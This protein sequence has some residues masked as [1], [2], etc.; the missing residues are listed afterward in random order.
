MVEP[1]GR[2]VNLLL[3]IYNSSPNRKRGVYFCIVNS[4]H[5]TSINT[6]IL[7][8]A[9]AVILAFT[10][11]AGFQ[12]YNLDKLD[13]RINALNDQLE[14][15][16]RLFVEIQ[17]SLGYGGVIHNLKN[18]IIRRNTRYFQAANGKAG[19]ARDYLRQ[20]GNLAS[21]GTDESA[22]V[23]FILDMVEKYQQVLD[24]LESAEISGLSAYELD[25]LI[26]VDDSMA[27]SA[28]EKLKASYQEYAAAGRKEVLNA[29]FVSF[30]TLISLVA[31][32]ILV[33]VLI[34]VFTALR[35]KRRTARILAVTSGI[36]EGDLRT[37]VDLKS[38]DFIGRMTASFDTAITRFRDIIS[39]IRGT[40]GESE[41]TAT[42]LTDRIEETIVATNRINGSINEL[43]RQVELLSSRTSGSSAAAEEIEMAILSL[44]KG[45]EN[46][47]SAVTQT[48]AAIEEMAASIKNVAG[49]TEIRMSSSKA[50]AQV[51]EQGEEQLQKTGSL[52]TGVSSSIDDML[53]MIDVIENV[54]RQT[55]MLSM[56]AAIEA[57]HAG[58]A[59]K[60][61][62]VVADEIRKLAESTRENSKQISGR[63]KEI[64]GVIQEALDSSRS[65]KGAFIAIRNGVAGALEAFNEI[66]N[67]TQ[68]LSAGT[69]EVVSAVA[70][71]MDI[72]GEIKSGS[73]EMKAGAGE[74][75][76]ALKG[77]KGIADEVDRE[78]GGVSRNA[79]EIAS[80]AMS[81]SQLGIA[82]DRIITSL[83]DQAAD[84]RLDD[85]D[86]ETRKSGFS[87]YILQHH[88]WVSRVG[89]TL[90][91][92]TEIS[93]DDMVDHRECEVGRWIDGTGGEQFGEHSAFAALSTAHCEL[94]TQ[95]GEILRLK[96]ESKEEEANNMY[97]QLLE[98]SR[99]LVGLFREL[100]ETMH[101][102]G[103]K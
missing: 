51:T 80:A 28:M 96:S 43:S 9:A 81:I 61:F 87:S 68:E 30:I 93:I 31:G 2:R 94:H 85:G 67:S 64:I 59:G 63:L 41:H 1:S 57:A 29:I 97:T 53:E 71:L 11:M 17:Q 83:V 6:Y 101:H 69:R 39:N 62:T 55:D 36:G 76:A 12:Y 99:R 22:Q 50:L 33:L 8:L 13:G 72:S 89:N 5:E 98:T 14:E 77:A 16:T 45:I 100:E 95:L 91:G 7:L 79:A 58:D 54:A 74:I 42:Q 23:A 26:Q 37:L 44:A 21:I 48:S 35:L 88:H 34:L 84:F 46:Q 24:Y 32:S 3:F 25:A 103:L 20:Y 90:A 66:H 27:E 49:V 40:I 15:R 82:N 38:R 86:L 102:P 60:G 65:T 73:E 52:I 92:N 19:L 56:N 75:R 70:S 10:L 78:I 18:Y 4:R 47:V